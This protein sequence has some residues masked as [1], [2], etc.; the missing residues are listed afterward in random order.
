MKS[1][2]E[3]KAW[4]KHDPL[5]AVSSWKGEGN[6]AALAWTD[7]E[8]YSLGEKDWADFKKRWEPYGITFRHCLKIGCGAGRIT[9]QLAKTSNASRRLMSPRIKSPTARRTP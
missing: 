6:D 5:F 7:E 8:F 4:G 9:N 3:W 1:N 2:A